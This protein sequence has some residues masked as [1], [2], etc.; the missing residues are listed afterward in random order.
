MTPRTRGLVA[1]AVV[2]VAI[3]ARKGRR[4]FRCWWRGCRNVQR[5]RLG[6][7][8]CRDCGR[9]GADLSAF[10]PVDA[11]YLNAHRSGR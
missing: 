7:F 11:G 6:L 2:L 1:L 5:I 9:K 8:R 3:G 10:G 4:R